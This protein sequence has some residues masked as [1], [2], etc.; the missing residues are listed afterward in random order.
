M[1]PCRDI[2]EDCLDIHNERCLM[3]AEKH[4]KLRRYRKREILLREG[5]IQSEIPFLLSGSFWCYFTDDIGKQC[6]DSIIVQKGFPITAT[7]DIRR[8]GEPSKDYIEALEAS[9]ALCLPTEIVVRMVGEYSEASDAMHRLIFSALSMHREYQRWAN[10]TLLDRYDMFC[11]A[12]PRLSVTL[13]K[14]AIAALLNTNLP[15]F[16]RT[17][18]GK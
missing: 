11:R 13:S 5:E 14:T 1:D 8:F 2:F 10:S 17:R 12:Y 7:A 3:L 18:Q 9:E 6:M 4:A 15:T 16:I